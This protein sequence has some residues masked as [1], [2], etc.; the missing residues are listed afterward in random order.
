MKKIIIFALGCALAGFAA[1]AGDVAV[2]EDIGFSKDGKTY[3]FG[4]Y[5]KTD[6]KFIPYGEIYGVDVAKNEYIPGKVFNYIYKDAG[7][8][9]TAVAAVS[10]TK[11]VIENGGTLR[12]D[13]STVKE[14]DYIY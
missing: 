2:F 6:K 9:V 1:F 8:D 4:E 11:L 14:F 7:L 12:I 3:F 5:G 13:E 10:D